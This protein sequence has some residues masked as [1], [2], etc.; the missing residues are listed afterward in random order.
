[1][2]HHLGTVDLLEDGPHSALVVYS[3]EVSPDS[4]AP[5]MAPAVE[6]GVRGL[7]EHLESS[8]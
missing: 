6:A 3:P 8:G 7:K 4:L 5:V 2:E 1:M